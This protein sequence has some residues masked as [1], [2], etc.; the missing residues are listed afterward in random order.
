MKFETNHYHDD[1]N[2]RKSFIAKNIGFGN[3]VTDFIVDKG[4]RNGEEIHSVSSTGIITI[5]NAHTYKTITMLI[6]SPRQLKK[7]YATRNATP[8]EKL[9][10]I[11]AEHEAKG[12]NYK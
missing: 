8:P 1:R 6:A 2:D 11:A 7:L 4:H 3:F 5:Y 9:L 10:K 12:W